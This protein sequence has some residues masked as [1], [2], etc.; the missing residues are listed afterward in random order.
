MNPPETSQ[1]PPETPAQKLRARIF[2]AVTIV[3]GAVII[4]M[5]V[6][7]IARAWK[8]EYGGG[9]RG[10]ASALPAAPR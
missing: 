8:I 7:R 2:A 4:V 10:P 5:L 6:M 3:V 9:P 1:L